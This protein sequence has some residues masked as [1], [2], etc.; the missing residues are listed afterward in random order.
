MSNL[1]VVYLGRYV[2]LNYKS[3]RR[4]VVVGSLCEKKADEDFGC[5]IC[6]RPISVYLENVTGL[7]IKKFLRLFMFF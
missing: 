7:N 5:G 4:R 6:M 3:P 1:V 2:L